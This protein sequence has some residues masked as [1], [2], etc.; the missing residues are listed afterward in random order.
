MWIC[1]TFYLFILK[2]T[3]DWIVSPFF[4][5]MSNAALN[6]YEETTFLTRP[7]A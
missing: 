6:I 5:I 3:D 1:T 4:A 2:L 7:P